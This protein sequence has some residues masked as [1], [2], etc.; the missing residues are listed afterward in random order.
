MRT[1]T[2]I[3]FAGNPFGNGGPWE[4][5]KTYVKHLHGKVSHLTMSSP[6]LQFPEILLKLLFCR[7]I[8]FSGV[9]NIDHLLLPL[10]RLF[11]KRILF[12]MHGCLAYEDAQN[13][14]HNPRGERNEALLLQHA[15]QILCVSEPY[16]QWVSDHYPHYAAKTATLTNGINWRSLSLSKSRHFDKHF[17]KLSD[18]APRDPHRIILLGGGR[19]TKH[20]LEVC[21]AVARLN[22]TRTEPYHIDIYGPFFANDHSALLQAQ[23]YTTWHGAVS[24]DAL[25]QALCESALFIQNSTFEP[26][27]LGVVEALVCG[28]SVLL[29][30]HVGARDI[31]PAL[32]EADLITDPTDPQRLARQIE[33]VLQTGNNQRLLASIDRE[34]TSCEAAADRL[35]QLAVKLCNQ[36]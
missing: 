8:I 36:P 19:V 7:V 12:I 27:S 14:Y 9:R 22:E 6:L 4:V 29:S 34:A 23:P 24:H 2:R 16:R 25:L 13:H 32:T 18:R 11:R 15:R 28:C 31:L 21:Q 33:Q 35:Y 30:V 10:C 1:R 26:F 5:N 17:D 3:F 20:N